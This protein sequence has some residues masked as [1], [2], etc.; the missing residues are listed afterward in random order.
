M[1][2]KCRDLVADIGIQFFGPVPLEVRPLIGVRR[3]PYEADYDSGS[4]VLPPQAQEGLHIGDHLLEVDPHPDAF[5]SLLGQPVN[6]ADDR[7]QPSLEDGLGSKLVQLGAIRG[8]ACAPK[9]HA[10]GNA[11]LVGNALVQQRF[12]AEVE[13]HITDPIPMGPKALHDASEHVVAHHAALARPLV[14]RA[15]DASPGAEP[16]HGLD[17]DMAR[18]DQLHGNVLDP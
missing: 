1:H 9:T 14:P 11:N 7:V 15:H 18:S 13:A 17:L 4:P 16:V 6:A 12:A 2:V 5:V 8:E 3:L 10:L